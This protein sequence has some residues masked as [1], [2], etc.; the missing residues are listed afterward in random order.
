MVKAL[1]STGRLRELL[2]GYFRELDRASRE[3]SPRI[4][5]CSSVG[6]AELLVSLGFA[7]YYPE[8]HAAMLGAVRKAAQTIPAALAA[9]FSPDVCSYLTSDIGAFL[10][11]ETPLA[12]AYP[13]IAAVP[14]PDVLVYNNVQC[15]DIQD[16]FAWYGRELGVPVLGVAAPRHVSVV[17]PEWLA[18]LAGQLRGLV[19]PLEAI[20]GRRFDLDLLKSVLATSRRGS[21]AWRR[22]LEANRAV[23]A[24]MSFFDA[25][26]QM[27]PAVV[28]RGRPD[29]SVYYDALL[30]ELEGRIARGE[31]A[32]EGERFRFYWEGMPIWGRLRSLADFFIGLRTSIAASTYA[33]SWVFEG[34]EEPDPF[35]AMAR[36]AAGLFIARD[37]DFKLS[38]LRDM[39]SR[40]GLHGFLFHDAKTCPFNS[41]NRY[42]LPGRLE[43]ATGLPVLT[44]HGDVNDLGCFA[45][46][47]TRTAV[48][49]FIERLEGA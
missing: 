9:G 28:L 37:D 48:E 40:F 8:N 3:R 17:T 2:A 38:Y 30:R 10:R 4:A 15:R 25:V 24:P 16:W 35:L 7:V 27:A 46:E 13:G 41:N 20:A 11:R 42:G 6:P 39:A 5:W 33:H 22:V 29:V 26:N 18:G 43:K 45:E 19:A 32:V 36:N 44:I 21:E 12:Q 1:E 31:G 23:P 34:G 14:R 47:R 49:A